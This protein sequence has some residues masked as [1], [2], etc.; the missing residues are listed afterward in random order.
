MG[1]PAGPRVFTHA[2][3]IH[4]VIK[5]VS[6]RDRGAI[7]GQTPRSP[8][9]IAMAIFDPHIGLADRPVQRV[10]VVH[11]YVPVTLALEGSRSPATMANSSATVAGSCKRFATS[12]APRAC[13]QAFACSTGNASNSTREAHLPG[14]T[15]AWWK[16]EIGSFVVITKSVFEPLA[17]MPSVTLSKRARPWPVRW[18]A[19]A[20]KSSPVSSRMA[21]RQRSN[22]WRSVIHSRR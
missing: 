1:V 7:D 16:R 19:S 5:D 12:E 11:R 13:S 6:R 10:K 18:P 2:G 14:R 20:P 4:H 21:T 9:S 22:G 15:T 8:P 17:S 3:A